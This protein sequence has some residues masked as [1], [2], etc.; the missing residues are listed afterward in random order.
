M[1]PYW[2]S[3]SIYLAPIGRHLEGYLYLL[4][5]DKSLRNYHYGKSIQTRADQRGVVVSMDP[6]LFGQSTLPS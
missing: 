4:S 5:W 2:S 6:D 1:A 3:T